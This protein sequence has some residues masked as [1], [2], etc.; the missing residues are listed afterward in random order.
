MRPQHVMQF[1]NLV[2]L[3]NVSKLLQEA[4][5]IASERERK[6]LLERGKG[7]KERDIGNG[8]KEELGEFGADYG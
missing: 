1:F 2:L 7:R 8:Q 4:F 5:Q 3:G 6:K